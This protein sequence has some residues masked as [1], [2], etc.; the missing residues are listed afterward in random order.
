[1]PYDVSSPADITQTPT[2]PAEDVAAVSHDIPQQAATETDVSPSAT[3]STPMPT[4]ESASDAS[5]HGTDGSSSQIEEPEAAPTDS[6]DESLVIVSPPSQEELADELTAEEQSVASLSPEL[7]PVHIPDSDVD[8][9]VLDLEGDAD[10]DSAS[11]EPTTPLALSPELS[12]VVVVHTPETPEN[13]P[14]IHAEEVETLPI[15]KEPVVSSSTIKP[16]SEPEPSPAA[17]Q[18]T[19]AEQ[20][21]PTLTQYLYNLVAPDAIERMRPPIGYSL[22]FLCYSLTWYLVTQTPAQPVF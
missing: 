6:M 22:T 19:P 7:P 8:R 12:S 10:S 9:L 4:P 17:A 11:E 2:V 3:V 13:E 21:A 20:P 5:A 18:P 14:A 16:T 1:V 15:T